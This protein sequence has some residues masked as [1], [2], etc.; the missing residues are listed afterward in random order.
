VESTLSVQYNQLTAANGVFLGWG[1]GAANNDDPWDDNQ[2]QVI[3]FTVAGGLRLFYWPPIQ[4]PSTTAYRWSF[5]KPTGKFDLPVNACVSALPD[6]FG[7]LESRITIATS[8]PTVQPWRIEQR[9]SSQIRQMFVA[10]PQQM[11]PPQFVAIEQIKGTGPQQ[12]NRQQL[13]VFPLAD[14]QYTLQCQYFISPDYLTGA[15]PYAY[16]GPQHAQ[17][18]IEACLAQAEVYA[19]DVPLQN[20][21]HYGAFIACLQTSISLDRSMKPQNLGPNIDRSDDRWQAERPWNLPSGRST[22]NGMSFDP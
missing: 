21:V 16:G 15:F 2:Q 3:D 22:Y 14:Q 4:P 7:G 12:S 1:R 6:D 19:D 18:Q 13:L 10:R 5:L 8:P 11:G 20:A 17:T 9:S